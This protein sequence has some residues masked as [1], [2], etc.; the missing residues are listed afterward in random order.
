MQ[1]PKSSSASSAAAGTCHLVALHQLSCWAYRNKKVTRQLVKRYKGG[2]ASC[3]TLLWSVVP[4]SFSLY[5]CV[6][7]KRW[8]RA[9]GCPVSRGLH[10]SG[11]VSGHRDS[12]KTFLRCHITT[13][14]SVFP[15][16]RRS[17]LAVTWDQRPPSPS[18]PLLLPPS[19]THHHHHHHSTL[20]HHRRRRRAPRT[21]HRTPHITTTTPPPPPPPGS[22]RLRVF[23]FESPFSCPCGRPW[24][25]HAWAAVRARPA[26]DVRD[27]CQHG[28]AM[29]KQASVRRWSR[30]A[31]QL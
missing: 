9:S 17:F 6:L 5:S 31:S 11:V 15:P 27:A 7:R 22:K 25:V 24:R 16:L 8:V 29:S 21:A 3:R 2:Q 13:Q 10:V 30:P 20:H 1:Q 23:F 4:P 26:D 14:R 28:G 12:L 18:L 19:H